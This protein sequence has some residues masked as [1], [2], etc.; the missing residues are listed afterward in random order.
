[1]A[2]LYFTEQDVEQLLDMNLALEA[3][4]G[5]FKR[6]A[7]QQ[8]DNVPRVRAKS[9]GIVLHSMSATDQGLNLVGWKQYTTTAQG[10]ILYTSWAVSPTYFPS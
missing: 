7:Q 10:A 2:C 4:R 1:M 5:A 6:M 8:I 3:M 9:S